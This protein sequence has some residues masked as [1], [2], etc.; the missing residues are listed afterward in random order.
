MANMG[1]PAERTI[2]AVV[3]PIS[4]AG[5][6]DVYTIGRAVTGT[7]TKVTYTP[8]A[9]VTASANP[10]NRTYSL[11]NKGADG[12]GTTV[13]ATRTT[14][15]GN[16]LSEF[17]EWELTLSATA[18]NLVVTDGDILAWSSTGNGTG[19]ADPG[20]LA[21]VYLDASAAGHSATGYVRGVE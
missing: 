14:V 17:D 9:D 3:P 11:I 1:A 10:N 16:D 18:A 15:T 7:V 2:S 5:D 21:T 12:T 6:D 8:D 4:T 20:G 13:V 19:V